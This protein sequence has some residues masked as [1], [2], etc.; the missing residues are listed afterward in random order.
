MNIILLVLKS[1]SFMEYRGKYSFPIITHKE[2]GQK[3]NH[4]MK[5]S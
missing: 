5:N 3:S 1:A 4:I 2:N